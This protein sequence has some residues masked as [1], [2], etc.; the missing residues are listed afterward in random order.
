MNFDETVS[1]TNSF[2]LQFFTWLFT[3]NWNTTNSNQ[4]L[5]PTHTTQLAPRS[6]RAKIIRKCLR[7][8]RTTLEAA[9][10]RKSFDTPFKCVAWRT[11]KRSAGRVGGETFSGR[12]SEAPAKPTRTRW[13]QCHH[14][15][16]I[17]PGHHSSDSFSP[18]IF[19]WRPKFD[20]PQSQDSVVARSLLFS[21]AGKA[22]LRSFWLV[23]FGARPRTAYWKI[24]FIYYTFEK[25]SLA[26]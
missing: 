7:W 8:L 2:D 24:D 20:A 17:S 21:F 14:G 10:R 5:W 11:S 3:E 16:L 6:I 22:L 23:V 13:R 18:R 1:N 15:P 25:N 12:G 4:L 19:N 9:E 26:N